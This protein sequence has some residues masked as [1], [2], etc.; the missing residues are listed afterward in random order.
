M[1]AVA[2]KVIA[3]VDDDEAVRTA[4][5]NLLRSLGLGVAVFDSAEAFLASPAGLA[6]SCV[7]TDVQMRGM[8]GLELQRQI[9]ARDIGMPV[10]L[11]TAFP[12]D[13]ARRQA[14][15]AGA[16]G[17]LAKP[18]EGGRLIECIEKALGARD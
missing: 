7:V 16:C 10:I 15:A 4:I 18:F 17:Y 11:I 9:A 1:T 13:E 8:N 3:V 6:A 2:P 12:R 14:E 5:E